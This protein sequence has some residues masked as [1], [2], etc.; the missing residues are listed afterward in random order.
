MLTDPKLRSQVDALW[1]KFW[2]G[3][4]SN[5]L[6]A[7]EQ[8]SYLLFLKQ[9]EERENAIERQARRRG[10]S[11]K[12]IE[13]RR[14]IPKDILWSYWSNFEA[15]K[16]LGHL[17]RNVFPELANLASYETSS[18]GQYMRNAE[19]K[20]NKPS[21]LIEACRLIDKMEISAQNQ[22]VQGDLYEYML[23]HMQFAGR[24]G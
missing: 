20:I 23:S 2:T 6:D 7:I 12:A 19:C 1:D 21:L 10:E 18:Y 4:L 16:A 5:P 9:L 24:N 14:R 15:E 22:D 11:S 17:K 8:F 13:R 3:G